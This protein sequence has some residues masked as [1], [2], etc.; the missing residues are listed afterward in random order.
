MQKN[1]TITKVASLTNTHLAT[2]TVMLLIAGGLAFLAIPKVSVKKVNIRSGVV[3]VKSVPKNNIRVDNRNNQNDVATTIATCGAPAGGWQSGKRYVLSQNITP[4]VNSFVPCF[5]ISGNNITLDGQNH[6]IAYQNNAARIAIRVEESSVGIT[7]KNLHIRGFQENAISVLRNT[8]NIQI[9]NNVFEDNIIGVNLSNGN[10][11]GII[12]NTFRFTGQFNPNRRENFMYGIKLFNV[13]GS[14]IANNTFE[15][16]ILA[17]GSYNSSSNIFERNVIHRNIVG[18]QV[19][20]QSNA[21]TITGT[22]FEN[23]YGA[24]IIISD[25]SSQNLVVSS[26]FRRNGGGSSETIGAHVI[27][28]A[29]FIAPAGLDNFN[30]YPVDAMKMGSIVILGDRS[31]QNNIQN[32]IFD[33]SLSNIFFVESSIRTTIQRNQI[34]N[35]ISSSIHLKN[36]QEFTF[37][38]NTLRGNSSGGRLIE[39]EGAGTR[40]LKIDANTV[41]GN[42]LPAELYCAREVS[43]RDGFRSA[44]NNRLEHPIVGNCSQ[45]FVGELSC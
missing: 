29:Q 13:Q 9:Q 34:V 23:N 21:N 24:G 4:P 10:T 5:S 2:A 30:N 20:G 7:L 45:A 11:N 22:T 15:N 8:V 28:A 39:I 18:M 36:T 12:G 16:L 19:V 38:G 17:I 27:N 43:I 41:C 35:G 31:E 6:T 44:Q 33:G 42:F 1:K 40:G 3:Q 26:T 14:R 32:N 25:S 37:S